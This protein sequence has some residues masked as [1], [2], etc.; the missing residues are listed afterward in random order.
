VQLLYH[1]S[2]LKVNPKMPENG[3]RRYAGLVQ[4]DLTQYDA[5]IAAL[6][7]TQGD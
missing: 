1:G 3:T 2:M 6:R 7:L 5:A 4:I